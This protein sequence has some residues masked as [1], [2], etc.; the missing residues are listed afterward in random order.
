MKRS[1][2]VGLTY[3]GFLE[4]KIW[5][6]TVRRLWKRFLCTRNVHMFDEEASR[7]HVLVCDACGLCVHIAL[8]ETEEESCIRARAA[9]YIETQAVERS[10]RDKSHYVVIR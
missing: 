9:L 1:S 5:E 3:P 4:W 6:K 10:E 8:I 2:Y 7:E